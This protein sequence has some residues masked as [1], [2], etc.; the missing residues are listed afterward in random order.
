MQLLLTQSSKQ[1]LHS[2]SIT[3][4]IQSLKNLAEGLLATHILSKEKRD[5]K[6]EEGKPTVNP[7]TESPLH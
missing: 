3:G 2:Q 5:S 6:G 7:Q 4:I 1:N